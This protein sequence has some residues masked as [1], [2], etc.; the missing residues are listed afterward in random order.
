MST[1]FQIISLCR[2]NF[3]SLKTRARSAAIISVS[4]LAV[5][6]VFTIVLMIRDGMSRS[7]MRP[8]ADAIA[9]VSS[10]NGLGPDAL[11]IIRQMP[12]VAHS[13]GRALVSPVFFSAMLL[14]DWKPGMIGLTV[15]TGISADNT[16]LLPGFHMTGG[17]MYRAGFNEM[18][19]G[20][21]A[22]KIYPQYAIGRNIEWMHHKWHIV[23]SYST[24]SDV[25]D[26]MFVTDFRQAQDTVKK[27]NNFSNIYVQLNR[28]SDYYRF[29]QALERHGNIS[30]VVERISEGDADMDKPFRT[31]LTLADVVIT[32]LMAVG[33]I[34]AALNVMHA[35]VAARKGELAILRAL[36]FARLPILTAILSEAL[37]LALTGGIV[38]VCMVGLVF[39]GAETSTIMGNR[40]VS[41]HMELTASAAMTAL[42]LTLVMGFIGGLFP[43][44]RAARLPIAAALHEG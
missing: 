29:K 24:G 31:V 11:N 30:P 12:G 10:P 38:A 41:F 18:I 35:A 1:V 19:I 17:R 2:W 42:G 40:M 9:R 4:F 16:R 32:V 39:S 8:G 44:I 25:Q 26:S 33:A 15:I 20:E 13:S 6:L 21:G 36:G 43:A 34:F 3:R 37:I 14:R 23:G 7:A 5:I 22:K 28:P 27:G